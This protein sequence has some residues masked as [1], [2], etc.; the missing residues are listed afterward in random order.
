MSGKKK[1]TV[2]FESYTTVHRPRL[3]THVDV[4]QRLETT[5]DPCCKAPFPLSSLSGLVAIP[6]TRARCVVQSSLELREPPPPASS[7]S[8]RIGRRWRRRRVVVCAENANLHF[9]DALLHRRRVDGSLT[10]PRVT[11]RIP[12]PAVLRSSLRVPRPSC[13]DTEKKRKIEREEKEIAA[14]VVVIVVARNCS[15][16]HENALC[17]HRSA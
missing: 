15:C 13:C 7:F 5:S 4:P 11:P 6:M 10:A 16:L 8:R 9:S 2:C 12:R 14:M 3:D 17:M 1:N